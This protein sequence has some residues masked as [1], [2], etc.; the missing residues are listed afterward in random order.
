MPPAA[1]IGRARLVR[2]LADL[3]SAEFAVREAASQ[4]LEGLGTT[5][6][7]ALRQ[8]LEAR[9]SPEVRRRLERLLARPVWRPTS[10]SDRRALRAVA[11]LERIGTTPAREL[12]VQWGLGAPEA[13]LTREAQAAVG[14]MRAAAAVRRQDR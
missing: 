13:W 6:R 10:A 3:D 2:L 1:E 8:A 14:R 9:P 5:V 12:L 4:E 11:V 7:P